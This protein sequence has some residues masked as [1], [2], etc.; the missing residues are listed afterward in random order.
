MPTSADVAYTVAYG[1]DVYLG[2]ITAT[3]TAKSNLTTVVPFPVSP[4]AKYSLQGDGEFYV[5]SASGSTN[6]VNAA[7]SGSGVR[8]E[9][10]ALYDRPLPRSHTHIAVQAVAGTVNVKVFEII[11]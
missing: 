1:T 10:N 8:V 3:G 4:G 5:A 6:A 11:S 7:N 9:A 2:T